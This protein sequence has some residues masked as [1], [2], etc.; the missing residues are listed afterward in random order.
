MQHNND[1]Y[2]ERRITTL[3]M[4]FER[5][6]KKLDDIISIQ[7]N[8]ISKQ[9]LNFEITKLTNKMD[10]IYQKLDNKIDT[11]SI[12]LD[13]KIENMKNKIIWKVGGVIV[14]WIT[15]YPFVLQLIHK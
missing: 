4:Q 7:A 5:I 3:E 2:F 6:D 12:T 11:N 1:I 8:F 15:I 13:N 14:A 9:D 10:V